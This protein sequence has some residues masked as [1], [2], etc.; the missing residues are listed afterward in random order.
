MS[1]TNTSNQRQQCHLNVL[2]DVVFHSLFEEFIDF[3]S[4]TLLLC[5]ANLIFKPLKPDLCSIS[6]FCYY[7][8][9]E[10]V[11]LVIYG[12]TTPNIYFAS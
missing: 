1:C 10:Q 7:F 9:T 3:L 8:K 4:V 11:N 6:G 12:I 5:Q 2:T